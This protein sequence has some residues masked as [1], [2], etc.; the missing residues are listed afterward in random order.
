[1]K[2]EFYLIILLFLFLILVGCDN[3]LHYNESEEN[4]I[5]NDVYVNKI[6]WCNINW[7]QI[8]FSIDLDENVLK[9]IKPIKTTDAAIEVAN[10]IIVEFHQIGKLSEYALISIT[11][12]TKDNIWY[13]EYSVDQ[14]NENIDHLIDCGCL[15]VAIDGNKGELI[16]AWVEE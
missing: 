16:K 2:K 12:S 3:T 5:V 8:E 4:E 10:D 7:D 11:H 14:R 1:M 15:Y 9:K 6:E 13:F